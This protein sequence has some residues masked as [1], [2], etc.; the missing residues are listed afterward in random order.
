LR[1]ANL[2]QFR[3][4]LGSYG[5][6]VFV[7]TDKTKSGEDVLNGPVVPHASWHLLNLDLPNLA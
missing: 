6:F 5:N 2:A 4:K 7:F 1:K 3:A